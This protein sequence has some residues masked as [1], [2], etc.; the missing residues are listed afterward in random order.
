MTLE[1]INVTRTPIRD[2]LL[3]E[4]VR[5]QPVHIEHAWVDIEDTLEKVLKR[6]V[7]ERL[8]RVFVIG[9]N[10]NPLKVI[11]VSDVIRFLLQTIQ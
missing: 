3:G 1:E 9:D 8:K 5:E 2:M 4:L 10:D 6:M 11:T 7:A